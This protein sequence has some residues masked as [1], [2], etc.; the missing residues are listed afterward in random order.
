MAL[1]MKLELLLW[2]WFRQNEFRWCPGRKKA[3][4]RLF[5]LLL[6]PQSHTVCYWPIFSYF[7]LFIL[8]DR[9]PYQELYIFIWYF[10]YLQCLI[11]VFGFRYANM[12]AEEFRNNQILVQWLCLWI[13]KYLCWYGLF[14]KNADDVLATRKQVLNRLF[15]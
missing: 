11:N 7:F 13:W 5:I 15:C 8:H 10:L 1:H 4:I 14:G 12:E 9:C 6:D 2:I 3:S